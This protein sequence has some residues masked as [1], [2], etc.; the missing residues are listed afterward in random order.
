MPFTKGHKFGK[1]FKKGHIPWIKGR[2]DM[3]GHKQ[4]PEWI[5]K[6]VVGQLGKKRTLEMRKKMSEAR[7]KGIKE[8]R[9]KAWNKGIK[10]R[11]EW[12]N[13][14]GLQPGWNKGM[15]GFLAGEKLFD[16]A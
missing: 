4:S 6:R 8:G 14:D 7:A 1:R 9:I 5:A 16:A 11:Q 13:T 3:G 12:M 10:G 15:I 2:T